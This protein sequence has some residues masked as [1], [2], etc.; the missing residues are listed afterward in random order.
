MS[1]VK[2]LATGIGS[3]PYVDAEIALDL[4][5]KYVP[6][7][8][9]WPQLPKRSHAEAMVA[10]F[11][12][13]LPCLELS[14][15]GLFFNPRDRDKQLE[16]F[17]DRIIAAD[18]NHFRI[19][20]DFALGLHAFYRSLRKRSLDKVEFIK[21][22][23][24]G[25]FTFAASL[26][27]ENKRSLLHEDVFM[28]AMC[29]GLIMKA[30]WQADFF[31][32]FGK[33]I[34]MFIDEP[35]LGAFG[36]AYTPLDRQNVVKTL[37]EFTADIKSDNVL[38]G[39][40]CCGNTDWSIFT[41]TKGIDIIN[42]DA[43][44]F[45]DKFLLYAGNLKS[46]LNRGGIICWGI[47][48]TQQWSGQETAELLLNRLKNGIDTLVKKGIDRELLLNSL[49]VSPSCGLGSLQPEKAEGVFGLLSQLSSLLR[50]QA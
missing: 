11:S 31:K 10:Q 14:A 50:K 46:F 13:N 44:D 6:H 12:E 48:P 3:L 4:V 35:Y 28:Q 36:S 39:V 22:H 32:E 18:L 20:P 9:F 37:D 25:P 26:N 41:E 19:S 5:F 16:I 17:Y 47:V 1:K 15:D 38:V 33:K 7:A 2:G 43:F 49:M 8:P 23:I 30:L 42:F 21:C 34:I 27:D 40:H 45:M 24:T 29:K